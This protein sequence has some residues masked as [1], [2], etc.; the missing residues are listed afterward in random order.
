VIGEIIEDPVQMGMT[1]DSVLIKEI[2]TVSGQKT[3][4]TKII[5]SIEH[6]KTLGTLNPNQRIV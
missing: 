6:E 1:V 2:L 4:V 3:S 5:N